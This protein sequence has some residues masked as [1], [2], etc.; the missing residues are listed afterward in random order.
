MFLC[1]LAQIMYNG[2]SVEVPDHGDL[3]HG[4]DVGIETEDV[5]YKHLANYALVLQQ[6]CIR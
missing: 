4:D 5:L 2:N 3:M 1:A 6:C